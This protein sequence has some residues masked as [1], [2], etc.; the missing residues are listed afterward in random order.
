MIVAY[1]ER[2]FW[3]F[4]FV[5]NKNCDTLLTTSSLLV[6]NMKICPQLQQCFYRGR[7]A[8]LE[9]HVE[10]RK[11]G[12][13]A[14]SFT[15][16]VRR[17]VDISSLHF[18]ITATSALFTAHLLSSCHAFSNSWATPQSFHISL[19]SRMVVDTIAIKKNPQTR[20]I[21]NSL[22]RTAT[23][24]RERKTREAKTVTTWM[25]TFLCHAGC[26]TGLLSTTDLIWDRNWH[27]ADCF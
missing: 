14:V 7:V 16:C 22:L 13:C 27:F 18:F 26:F 25:Q 15:S 2:L 19:L 4:K 24:N 1:L 11:K 10:M 12:L 17:F 3:G 6:P 9:A 5:Q 8:F 21:L 23:R 20:I